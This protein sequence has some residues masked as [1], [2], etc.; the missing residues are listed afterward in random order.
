MN[1]IWI[2]AS[3]H[4]SLY[5][6][7]VI[8]PGSGI[9]ISNKWCVISYLFLILFLCAPQAK[10]QSNDP[11]FLQ[12]KVQFYSLDD[13]ALPAEVLGQDLGSTW[14]GWDPGPVSD[15]KEYDRTRKGVI[16]L[17]SEQ[18]VARFDTLATD[19]WE[20]WQYF[21]GPRWLP[22]NDVEQVWVDPA[23]DTEKVWIRT[24]SGVA[25]LSWEP[26]TF[27]EK[28]S[29]YEKLNEARHVRKGFVAR[30][31]L[32]QP[33]DLSSS[34]TS[35]TDND[36]LWTAMHLAAQAYRFAVTGDVEARRLARRSLEAL[37]KLETI[38]PIPGFFARTYRTFDEPMP[39]QDNGE[40]H[41]VGDG[42][43]EWKGDTSSDESVGHYYGYALYFDLVATSDEKLEIAAYV[44]RLTDYMLEN[45]YDLIDIDGLPTRW[46]RWGTDY[47]E[48]PEGD[49][50]RALRS[51][52][53]LSFLKTTFQI[54][55]DPKYQEAY[56]ER[57]AQGYALNTLEYRRW[58]SEEWEI[59]YSDDELYYLSVYPLLK[60]ETD[61]ALRAIYLDGL[62][63]TW[64]QVQPER[65]ALWNFMSA[66]LGAGPLT[67]HLW[68][69][70]RS[71]LIR[72]PL[73]LIDWEVKNSHRIDVR[74]NGNP[75]RHGQNELVRVVAPDER[76]IH[77]H[78][79]N[80][81]RADGGGAGS[82]EMAGTYWLL[83]YWLGR[84]YGWL[85]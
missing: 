13:P 9:T 38:D 21:A 65:N 51:L 36:G 35:D 37:M 85:P 1:P 81:Y 43:T 66:A 27:V 23:S 63:F 50:E 24:G 60:Y 69:D 14:M 18:G 57:V 20:R 72:A 11:R 7:Q 29:H 76:P 10:G 84:F 54:T 46:G 73:D 15:L 28:A 42:L 80:P 52:E 2:P 48:T 61:P 45:N 31:K 6:T 33:G 77:K 82:T 26:M 32:I 47:Y 78:N 83:P 58:G 53:L 17:G 67:P 5:N 8:R 12:K 3:R 49:Y 75:D 70:S 79:G 4:E 34:V 22:S 68:N 56:L 62:R 39:H 40:W 74:L 71:S 55:G 25:S 16:W 64:Q 30:S 44:R 19:L 59:N 41:P